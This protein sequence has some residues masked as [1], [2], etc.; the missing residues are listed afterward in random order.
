MT[1]PGAPGPGA[2]G[3]G[4]PGP[5]RPPSSWQPHSRPG[6]GHPG[7]LRNRGRLAAS[8]ARDRHRRRRG[9]RDRCRG[10]RRGRSRRTGGGRGGGRPAQPGRAGQPGAPAVAAVLA[11]GP[12]RSRPGGARA[13]A[14]VLL[15][16][17]AAAFPAGRRPGV[18]GGLRGG[19]ARPAGAPARLAAGRTARD[20]PLRRPGR[21]AAGVCRGRS[22]P[23]QSVEVDRPR[24]AGPAGAGNG[25][26][27][28]AQATGPDGTS[29][30]ARAGDQPGIPYRT[31]ARLIDRLEHL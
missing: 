1:V 28:P 14:V 15:P 21:R 5:A 7:W 11:R 29:G 30:P 17:L 24:P 22:R 31:L 25:A 19:R 18:H 10:L 26:A 16:P 9:G 2:P 12:Q 6:A 3:A 8:T 4:A 13:S 20:Q 23:R 27:R